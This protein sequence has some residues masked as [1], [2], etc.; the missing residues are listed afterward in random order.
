M[1]MVLRFRVLLDAPHRLHYRA[2]DRNARASFPPV[3]GGGR[4]TN[5]VV[6]V[7]QDSRPAR[8]ILQWL[9]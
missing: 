5:L 3:H 2:S 8:T 4:D 9:A 1:Q 7:L 6:M